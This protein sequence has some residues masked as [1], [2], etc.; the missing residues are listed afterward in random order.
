MWYPY[1]LFLVFFT[2]AVG[3]GARYYWD[4]KKVAPYEA[5]GACG[6]RDRNI[7]LKFVSRFTNGV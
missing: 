6:D 4:N 5:Y 3:S 2:I 1:T 7:Y